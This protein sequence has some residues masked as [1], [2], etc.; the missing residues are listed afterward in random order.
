MYS[1]IIRGKCEILSEKQVKMYIIMEQK[2][3]KLSQVNKHLET[4]Q[5]MVFV[6]WKI[7]HHLLLEQ[8]QYQSVGLELVPL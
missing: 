8:L 3:R 7:N 1:V 4:K 6:S 2:K 5:I